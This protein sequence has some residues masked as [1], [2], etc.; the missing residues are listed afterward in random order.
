MSGSG[1]RRILSRR[2]LNAPQLNRLNGRARRR[3]RNGT[4]RC[5]RGPAQGTA[6]SRGV[7]N[8]ASL[9]CPAS[10]G[11]SARRPDLIDTAPAGLTSL[12]GAGSGRP[13]SGRPSRR[14]GAQKTSRA[15]NGLR[16][17]ASARP[18]INHRPF[19]YN[20]RQ[21]SPADAPAAPMNSARARAGGRA[22]IAR[23]QDR[24]AQIA[25]TSG[26]ANCPKELNAFQ[27]GPARQR[28]EQ[29]RGAARPPSQ[30]AAA[31]AA[32]AAAR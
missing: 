20:G 32:A 11:R 7:T 14:I 5:R 18:P 22:E 16:G 29:L 24:S 26:R 19:Q 23:R 6:K 1:G 15:G 9:P 13:L 30:F 25:E 8:R 12:S 3:A 31:A 28:S 21:K 4:R 27:M 17:P 10:A 2:R